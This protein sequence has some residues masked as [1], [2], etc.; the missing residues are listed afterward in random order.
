ME[1]KNP[2]KNRAL[3]GLKK[4]KIAWQIHT[5]SLNSIIAS[6]MVLA[7]KFVILKVCK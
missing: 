5:S 3:F 6:K 1:N 2:W 7:E 4:D